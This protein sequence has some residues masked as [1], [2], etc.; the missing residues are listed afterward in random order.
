MHGFL[1]LAGL[2]IAQPAADRS[3]VSKPAVSEGTRSVTGARPAGTIKPMRGAPCDT[4]PCTPVEPKE[5]AA[6]K[7]PIIVKSKG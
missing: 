6:A 5:A 3:A 2:M 1:I 4:P 7:P